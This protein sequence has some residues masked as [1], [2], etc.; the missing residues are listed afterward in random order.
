MNSANQAIIP[1]NDGW[2]IGF[3]S[4]YRNVLLKANDSIYYLFYAAMN[5]SNTGR[6]PGFYYTKLNRHLRNGQGDIVP[7]FEDVPILSAPCVDVFATQTSSGSWWVYTNSG[8]TIVRVK[9]DETGI[10]IPE[11]QYFPSAKS[12]FQPEGHFGTTRI[13][14]HNKKVI[15]Q[16][17]GHIYH[18][19]TTVQES[20]TVSYLFDYDEATGAFSNPTLLFE[21]NY[22]GGATEVHHRPILTEMEFSPNDSFVYLLFSNS[23]LIDTTKTEVWLSQYETFASDPRNTATAICQT[24]DPYFEYVSRCN[25]LRLGQNQKMYLGSNYWSTDIGLIEYP[26]RKGSA[27]RLQIKDSLKFRACSL[28]GSV[29]CYADNYPFSRFHG[30]KMDFKNTPRCSDSSILLENLC[31]TSKFNFYQ[32]YLYSVKQPGK[33]L[34]SSTQFEPV[35]S[36]YDSG[37]YYICLRA[38]TPKGFRP[39][40]SDTIQHYPVFPSVSFSTL[41]SVSCRYTE[42]LLKNLSTLNLSNPNL[43]PKWTFR[44]SDGRDTSLFSPNDLLYT[45]M[46]T[47]YHHVTLEVFNGYCTNSLHKDSFLYVWNAPRPGIAISDTLGCQPL[48]IQAKRLYRDSIL[49]AYYKPDINEDSFQ[50][51]SLIDNDAILY[52]TYHDPG[53][54]WLSQTLIGP[55]GCITQDSVRIRVQRGF[56]PN[57][58]SDIQL[59]GVMNNDSV[60]LIAY[61]HPVGIHHILEKSLE[62][63]RWIY[64]D[65][66]YSSS[67]IDTVVNVHKQAYYYRIK[68]V[69]SCGLERVGQMGTSMLLQ[70]INS[71]NEIILLTW[72]SYENWNQGVVKYD[73]EYQDQLNQWQSL[74]SLQDTSFAHREF[75][76]S[77]IN[78]ICYRVSAW[79]DIAGDSISYSNE[80]CVD[81]LPILWV[82]NAFSPNGDLINDTFFITTYGISELNFEIFNRYGERVFQGSRLNSSWNGTYKG[83][84]APEGTYLIRIYGRKQNGTFFNE[85]ANL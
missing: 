78:S 77:G 72:T 11:T 67:A 32:W 20:H 79:K 10:S 26:N 81:I 71:E 34:D 2:Y 36:H 41:D 27:C 44:F 59:A 43:K 70:G 80:T 47:G 84:S 45:F 23:N 82:P 13:S 17:Y 55:S 24:K 57:E 48:Q 5:P 40:F 22:R 74:N 61:L 39:W 65:S 14:P 56:Y 50:A 51:D 73:L 15:R 42:V 35:F 4:A 12:K 54:Y 85:N 28:S 25:N 1:N 83:E 33:L 21:S 16:E 7:D 63:N 75:L 60:Q 3:G 62:K 49:T 52:Y 53:V 30:L 31:D 66:L 19:N 6:L 9:V 64:L 76:K 58:Q 38:W 18:T 8:D 68:S 37:R 29:G 46:D 69:D